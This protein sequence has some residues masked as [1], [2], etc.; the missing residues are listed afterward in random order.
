M[1]ETHNVE[2]DAYDPANKNF[3]CNMYQDDGSRFSGTVTV[4]GN[5]ITWKESFTLRGSKSSSRSRSS[6]QRIE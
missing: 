2:I 6:W 1:G 3:I 4:D 5:T